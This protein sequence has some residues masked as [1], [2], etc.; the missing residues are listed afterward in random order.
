MLTPENAWFA[1]VCP[2]F[3]KAF[4]PTFAPDV[5][6]GRWLHFQRPPISLGLGGEESACHL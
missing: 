2:T 5:F 4:Q 3:P 6:E 1:A